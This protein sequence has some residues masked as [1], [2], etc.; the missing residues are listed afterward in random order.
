MPAPASQVSAVVVGH[1]DYRDAD[2]IVQL[3]T[4]PHG[5][6]S[7]L[8]RS[9]RRS[10]KRF[11]GALDLGNRVDVMLRP[12][13]GDLWHLDS[14]ELADGRPHMRQDLDRIALGAYCCELVASLARSEH[15][16]PRLFGLLDVALM[17]L[18]A[19]TTVPSACFRL[20]V[21]AKALTFS[22][23]TPVL[24]RC[25]ACGEDLGEGPLVLDPGSGGV[26]HRRCG[27]G[28][29][30]TAEEAEALEDI[31]RTPLAELV[32]REPLACGAWLLHDLLVWQT[33]RALKSKELLA[34]LQP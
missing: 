12:G 7:A 16:E 3:L 23:M 22:G 30:I 26:L 11:G 32:D 34:S 20:G 21:E 27:G 15:P 24:T 17:V 8:A 13:R 29:P 33:G 10:A 6:I 19:A 2:R 1:V 4:A 25:A 5:R 28:A 31:R 14:A 18:D 9:A